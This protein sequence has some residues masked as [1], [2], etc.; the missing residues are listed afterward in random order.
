MSAAFGKKTKILLLVAC[1]LLILLAGVK[2]WVDSKSIDQSFFT[3]AIMGIIVLIA[4]LIAYFFFYK[5]KEVTVTSG[6]IKFGKKYNGPLDKEPDTAYFESFN[7][8]LFL[9]WAE[10]KSLTIKDTIS[11]SKFADIYW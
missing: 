9:A 2:S 6:G 11:L 4:G 10:I 7:P 8:E 3:I 1:L 5:G